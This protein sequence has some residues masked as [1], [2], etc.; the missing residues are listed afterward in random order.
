M[1]V[2]AGAGHPGTGEKHASALCVR[3]ITSGVREH[4]DKMLGQTPTSPTAVNLMLYILML[5]RIIH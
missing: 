5:L 2:E 3:P 1:L 4:L